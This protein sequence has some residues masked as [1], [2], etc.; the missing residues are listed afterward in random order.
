MH[1]FD[2]KFIYLL[3]IIIAVGIGAGPLQAGKAGR[4]EKAKKERDRKEDAK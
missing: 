1:K 2:I 3:A 4:Y